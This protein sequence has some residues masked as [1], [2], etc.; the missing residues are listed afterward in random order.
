[1][2]VKHAVVKK[3]RGSYQSRKDR[4]KLGL[5]SVPVEPPKPPPVQGVS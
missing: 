5:G 1:M 2:V 4:G 3:A